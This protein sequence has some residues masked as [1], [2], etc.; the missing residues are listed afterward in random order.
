MK[1]HQYQSS[2]KIK[3]KPQWDSVTYL[4]EWKWKW[5]PLSH[6]WLFATPWNSPGQNTEVGGCSLLQM[7]FPTQG[8][9]PGLPHCRQI[10]YHLIH[11][12]SPRILKWVDYPF[13][14]RSSWPRNQTGVSCIAGGFFTSWAQ[15]K[16]KNTGVG[17]LP[18]LQRIFPTKELNQSLLDCRRI[19]YQLSYLNNRRKEV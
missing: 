2:G 18:L 10:L 11:Q 3:L 4:P 6:V 7:V 12:G 13:S 19:L 5:K 1:R 9:N 16:P 14:I 17:S 15:G 8:S